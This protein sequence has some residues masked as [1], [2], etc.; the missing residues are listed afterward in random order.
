MLRPALLLLAISAYL[1]AL[2]L[3]NGLALTPPLGWSTWNVFQFNVS[4]TLIKQM[5][6]AIVAR[7]I[8]LIS[9][10]TVFLLVSRSC[11]YCTVFL[12]KAFLSVS[13]FFF[14][15]FSSLVSMKQLGLAKYGYTYILIDDGWPSCS[16]FASG[17]GCRVPAPRDS[18]NR[19]VVFQCL[20]SY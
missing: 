16:S 5:A 2:A 1:P 14:H 20:K 17:G 13:T 9:C 4:E 12:V 10:I 6:N 15:L 19:I 18:Q 8:Y 3:D 7:G 11:F